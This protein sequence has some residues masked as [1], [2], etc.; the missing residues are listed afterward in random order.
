MWNNCRVDNI[1]LHQLR[2]FAGNTFD[3][4]CKKRVFR[5]TRIVYRKDQPGYLRSL[6]QE[7]HYLLMVHFSVI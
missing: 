1:F 2:Q 7:L 6:T 4:T 3:A 5:H